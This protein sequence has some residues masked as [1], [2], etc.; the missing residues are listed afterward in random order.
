VDTKKLEVFMD[1]AKTQNYSLS[2]ERMFL[3]QSTISKY[4]MVLEKNGTLNYL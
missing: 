3:S 1:L 4:I 2:A